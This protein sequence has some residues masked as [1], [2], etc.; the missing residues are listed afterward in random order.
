VSQRAADVVTE[1]RRA[2]EALA[3]ALGARRDRVTLVQR[4]GES[5]GVT[6]ERPGTSQRA[7][8]EGFH[9]NF[10]PQGWGDLDGIDRYELAKLK[11]RY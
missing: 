9:R 8:V 3:V 7:G 4:D 2:A 1:E 6:P 11:S 5:A 10:S